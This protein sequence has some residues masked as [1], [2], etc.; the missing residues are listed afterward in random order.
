MGG[1]GSGRWGYFSGKTKVEDCYRWHITGIKDILIPGH[2]GATRWMIGERESGSISYRVLG[3]EKPTALRLS[4]TIGARSGNPQD[5]NYRV[6]LTTTL[7]PWGGV[8]YWFVCPLQGCYR[9]VGCLYLPPGGK[10][11]G[12]RH[13]NDLSY[14]S[15]SEWHRDKDMLERLAGMMQDVYPGMNW[16]DTKDILEGKLPRHWKRLAAEWYLAEWQDYDRYEGYLTQ[17]ELCQKSGLT[18][19]G[20]RILE[21]ARLLLPDIQDGRYRPKLVGWGKKLAYLLGQGW[22]LEEIRR[23]SR[24]RFKTKNPK[25]W[26]PIRKD[27]QLSKIRTLQIEYRRKSIIISWM[28]TMYYPP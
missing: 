22:E 24:G 18:V 12:C 9:R 6:N 3:D 19:E 5:F 1:Y 17:D 20:L 11:F 26:P 15:Q 7:L 4:Y 10:Y 8:R 23:W 28:Q 14:E 16:E 13:C 25:Q 27:W 21:E 2:W